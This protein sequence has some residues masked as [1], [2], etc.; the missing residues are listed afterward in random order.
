MLEKTGRHMSSQRQERFRS[1][2]SAYCIPSKQ[3]WDVEEGRHGTSGDA[4]QASARLSTRSRAVPVLCQAR[5]LLKV[6]LEDQEENYSGKN[7]VCWAP[8]AWGFDERPSGPSAFAP[9]LETHKSQQGR[10]IAGQGVEGSPSPEQMLLM[11]PRVLS[12]LRVATTAAPLLCHPA[13][14]RTN[15]TH[16]LWNVPGRRGCSQHRRCSKGGAP[17]SRQGVPGGCLESWG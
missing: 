17:H 11:G 7:K 3:S 4:L 8:I 13:W 14:E 10:L 5:E 15:Q 12:G 9:L 1:A 6:R 16:V 2:H